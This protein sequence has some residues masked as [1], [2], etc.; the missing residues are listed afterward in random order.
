MQDLKK[1]DVIMM[2]IFR[3]DG[4]YSSTSISLAKEFAK[5]NRIFYINHPYSW[6][7]YLNLP[8]DPALNDRKTAL[9]KG[10]VRYE[11]DDK[12]SDNFTSVVAPLT[13]PINHFPKGGI[14]NRFAAHNNKKVVS[15]I[16]QVIKDFDITNYVFIN[17]FD[18]FYVPV[19]PADLK[20][21]INIY[22]CVD[23]ISQ[24][25]YIAK[26]GVYLENLAIK[27]AD[28]TLTTSS[29]LYRIKSA[30]T[31]S[32]H[33]L[34]NAAD[35]SG[36]QRA[37]TIDYPKPDEFKNITGKIIG[38]IGNL[39]EIRVNYPLLKKVA[40]AYPDDTLIL[41]GPINN[42]IYKEIGFLFS[43]RKMSP[44]L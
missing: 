10:E 7:D 13:I 3:W 34:N 4:P 40:E 27:K 37:L 19:L 25:D 20:P 8:N 15:T 12:L 17:C 11:K 24:S 33:I 6:K 23:D 35:I 31:N 16:R 2:A 32:I 44:I 26:H 42:T 36:F 21:A 28:L 41:I 43:F 9:K 30:F 39:D 14:Y 18:P 1:Y 29:E 22:Q 38:Y 5:S